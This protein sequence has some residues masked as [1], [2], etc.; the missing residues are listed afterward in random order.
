MEAPAPLDVEEWCALPEDEP[1]ELVNGRLVEEEV[2]DYVHELVVSW[3]I[4]QF[5][6]WLAGRAGFV[7][8]SEAKFAVREDRGRKPDVTVFLPGGAV[9][10]RRGPVRVPPDVAVEVVSPRPR[11]GQ[12]DRVEK[13]A[14]YASF[15]VRWYWILDPELRS[16]EILELGPERLYVHRVGRT[17]GVLHDVP[18][19]PGLSLDLDALWAE[20]DRLGSGS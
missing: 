8:G 10:P 14:D 16:L 11:D 18:G 7:A 17:D 19:C 4:H 5:R 1:G 12:R 6:L 15:G 2:P 13:V 9:P 20:V 3:L